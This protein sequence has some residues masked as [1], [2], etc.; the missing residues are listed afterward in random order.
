MHFDCESPG[1]DTSTSTTN[2]ETLTF[3]NTTGVTQ[4][5]SWRAY[6]FSD[7]RNTYSMTVTLQ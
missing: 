7:T 6:L 3:H 4:G 2:Q 5:V 1:I